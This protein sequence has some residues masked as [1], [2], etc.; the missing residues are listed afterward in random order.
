MDPQLDHL[1]DEIAKPC[2]ECGK[3]MVGEDC[4]HCSP[5]P[6]VH[7]HVHREEG[8]E[9]WMCDFKPPTASRR[10]IVEVTALTPEEADDGQEG[11]VIMVMAKESVRLG[12]FELKRGQ[13]LYR[14]ATGRCTDIFL[15]Q[16]EKVEA[17]Q[18]R[19]LHKHYTRV[20]RL[21]R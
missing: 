2:P 4:W 13:V 3:D 6:Y 18:M 17:A 12:D 20:R 19:T 5:P 14:R 10:L 15:G 21:N 11:L 9:Y 8:G 16:E 1:I 7:I